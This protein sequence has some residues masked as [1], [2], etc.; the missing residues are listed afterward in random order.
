MSD[1]NYMRDP[2]SE[3]S[4][5]MRSSRSFPNDLTGKTI[6]LLDISKERSSEFHDS[7][8]P[9]LS[10]AGFSVKRYRKAS[11]SKVA[12]TAITQA[13]VQHADIVIEGLAD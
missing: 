12:A 2:T 4:S 5:T 10:E 6:A 9:R 13:I 3:T 1:L 8:E 11:H 7:L